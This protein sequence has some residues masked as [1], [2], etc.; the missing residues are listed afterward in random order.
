MLI[1]ANQC[2]SVV[3]GR[4]GLRQEPRANFQLISYALPK[5]P[6]TPRVLRYPELRQIFLHGREDGIDDLLIR[7]R[8]DQLGFGGLTLK[9]DQ[10]HGHVVAV[11]FVADAQ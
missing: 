4:V 2:G 7:G 5:P 11:T 3:R 9:I 8:H 1:S 6:A 10:D